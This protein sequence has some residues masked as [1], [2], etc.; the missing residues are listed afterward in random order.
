MR[1]PSLVMSL[2]L[3]AVVF[4]VAASVS[5]QDTNPRFG[6]WKMKSDGKISRVTHA[7]Y[8]RIQ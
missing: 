3:I 2:A 7:T 4:V 8:E 5:A 1:K 6:V